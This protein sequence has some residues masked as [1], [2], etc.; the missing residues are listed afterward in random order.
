LKAGLPLSSVKAFLTALN[1][2]DSGA[3]AAVPGATE[4]VIN[5]GLAGLRTSYS[6][7]FTVVYLVSIAC[8][9]LSVIAAWF[10]P[11]LEDKIHSHDVVRR[12]AGSEGKQDKGNDIVEST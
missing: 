10:A 7:A 1:S 8:G 6:K 2:G 3:F 12:L 4:S 11:N 9:G 5:A